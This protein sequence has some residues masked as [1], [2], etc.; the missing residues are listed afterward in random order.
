MSRK[1]PE[2]FKKYISKEEISTLIQKMAREID[3]H[4]GAEA[5]L[6]CVGILKGA[7]VTLADLVREMKIKCT[8]DF[9]R[10]RSYG[11]SKESSGQVVIE[12]DLE[13]DVT[14]K[15]ILLV[16]EIIDT[17]RTLSALKDRLKDKGAASVKIA[18]LLDKKS[19]RVVPCDADFLGRDIEDNFVVGYGLDWAENYRDLE[20]IY[21]VPT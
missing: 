16:E 3:A 18:A 1:C 21:I 13:L 17:G 9:I 10:A 4:Y 19:H 6:I 15:H 12:K 14:G 7:W 11:E 20:D 2:D 8:I 5:D